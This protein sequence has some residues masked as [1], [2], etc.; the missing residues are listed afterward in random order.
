MILI[1]RDANDYCP[2]LL[3]SFASI[4]KFPLAFLIAFMHGF[5]EFF[6]ELMVNSC[7][8]SHELGK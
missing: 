8:L 2:G 4:C 3:T 1:N 5:F 6:F 7:W